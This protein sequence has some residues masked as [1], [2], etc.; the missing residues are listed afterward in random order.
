MT[1]VLLP[2]NFWRWLPLGILGFLIVASY[3]SGLQHYVGVQSLIDNRVMLLDFVHQHAV[4]AIV[5]YA[6]IYVAIVALS[7]P[8]SGVLSIIGG[9]IFSWVISAPV[10]IVAATIGAIIVFQIVK[11]SAGAVVAE[12]AGPFVANLSAGFSQDAMSYLLF[13][14]MVPVFPFFAINAV[15][16][17]TKVSLRTFT[18]GTFLGIIP[19]AYAFAYVGRGLGSVIDQ[20]TALHQACLAVKSDAECP[21]MLT[22]TSLVTPQLFSACAVL[23]VISLIPMAIKKWRML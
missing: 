14:R 13:L 21:F 18:I 22:A 9:F 10:S 23:G 15:A 20:Q 1:P 19:G 17:L 7:L 4:M 2:Q 16:G 12:R 3:A 11:T 6:A 5:I 8:G